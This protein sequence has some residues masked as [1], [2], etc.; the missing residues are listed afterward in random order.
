MKKTIPSAV[1]AAGTAL[2]EIMN[3]SDVCAALKLSRTTIWKLVREKKLPCIQ[4]S[5]KIRRFKRSDILAL[6]SKTGAK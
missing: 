6:K 2:P 3:L 1:A 5:S 4:L